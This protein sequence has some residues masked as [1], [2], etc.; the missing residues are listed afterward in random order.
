[1]IESLYDW[2]VDFNEACLADN[3]VLM[4]SIWK[5]DFVNA[6]KS[7]FLPEGLNEE[8]LFTFPCPSKIVDAIRSLFRS[9]KRDSNF[10]LDST[11]PFP[12]SSTS[13][14]IIFRSLF[15]L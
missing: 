8:N 14:L 3:L 9:G 1:M 6:S 5:S 2:L 12:L 4:S 10:A 13:F 15:G 11:I 7:C